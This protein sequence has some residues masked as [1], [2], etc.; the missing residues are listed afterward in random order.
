MIGRA[1]LPTQEVQMPAW[2][3]GRVAITAVGSRPEYDSYPIGGRFGQPPV[4]LEF[5][6][7]PGK[8]LSVARRDVERAVAQLRQGGWEPHSRHAF[9][10]RA[11]LVFRRPIPE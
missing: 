2:E 1:F 3:Y 10:D 6:I 4:L 8:D 11:T 9:A 5:Q 7:V